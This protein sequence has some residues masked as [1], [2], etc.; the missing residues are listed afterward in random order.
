[1]NVSELPP[2]LLSR[3]EASGL[4]GLYKVELRGV[5]DGIYYVRLNDSAEVVGAIADNE[6]PDAILR[7]DP[8]SL[9]A[10]LSGRMS[11][12]DAL[13]SERVSVAGDITKID[14]LKDALLTASS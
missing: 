6:H 9:T 8:E 13:V 5:P 7:G 3:L 12:S 10:L 4:Q 11:F 14:A 1:M 2:E